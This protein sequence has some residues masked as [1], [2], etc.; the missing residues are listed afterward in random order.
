[1]KYL[2]VLLV[3]V[4]V[5]WWLASRRPKAVARRQQQKQ[6]RQQAKPQA[7]L[8]C[9]HCGVHLPASEAVVDGSGS[10]C[11]EAHRLAGPR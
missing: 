3:V 2:I 5:G 7:M 11:S 6:Q 10:Y 9:T 1:M 4:A 8:S